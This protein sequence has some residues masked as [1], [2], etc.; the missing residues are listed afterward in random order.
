MY[1]N[2]DTHW[3]LYALAEKL[4]DV[5]TLFQRWRFDHVTAV[6]RV[7]GM[8]KGTGGSSGVAFLVAKKSA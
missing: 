5:E 2:T 1:N 7:I 4:M 3:N 8:Q 6:E